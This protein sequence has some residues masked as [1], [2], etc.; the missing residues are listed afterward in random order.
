MARK[1]K[2]KPFFSFY[3]IPRVNYEEKQV[4]SLSQRYPNIIE[5]CQKYQCNFSTYIKM[6]EDGRSK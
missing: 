5:R 3:Y 6:V 1:F 2:I 4:I